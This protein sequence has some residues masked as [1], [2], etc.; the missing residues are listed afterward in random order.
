LAAGRISI[1][2]Y[3][4]SGAMGDVFE[5]YDH[6]L[7]ATVALKALVQRNAAAIYQL[8]NEFRALVGVSHRNIVR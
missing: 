4:G 8:K 3:I 2:R 7:D 1:V 5:A 6:E